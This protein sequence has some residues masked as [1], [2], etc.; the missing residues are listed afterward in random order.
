MSIRFIWVII[1]KEGEDRVGNEWVNM[2]KI[3]FVNNEFVC[4][5]GRENGYVLRIF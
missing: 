5:R 2:Y 3:G 1:S 4:I